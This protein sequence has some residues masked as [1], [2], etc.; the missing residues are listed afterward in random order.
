MAA[1]PHGDLLLPSFRPR[2]QLLT[3][4][5]IQQH[6]ANVEWEQEREQAAEAL[7]LELQLEEQKEAKRRLQSAVEVIDLTRS[8]PID[9]TGGDDSSELNDDSDLFFSARRRRR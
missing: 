9:L 2:R 4:A 5:E 7:A 1:V 8:S 3:A 6:W